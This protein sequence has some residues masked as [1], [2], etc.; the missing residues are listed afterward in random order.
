M[1]K[2]EHI[3]PEGILRKFLEDY[4]DHVCNSKEIKALRAYL[5]KHEDPDLNS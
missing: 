4:C 3:I 5:W 1:T 2:K